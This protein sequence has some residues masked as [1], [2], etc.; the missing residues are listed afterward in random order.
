M[1]VLSLRPVG[2]AVGEYLNAGGV[3]S[4][5]PVHYTASVLVGGTSALTDDDDASYVY[6]GTGN[7]TEAGT[8]GAPYYGM[9]QDWAG[10]TLPAVTVDPST[11]TDLTIRARFKHPPVADESKLSG[12]GY[13]M[14][15]WLYDATTD[16]TL[17]LAGW[18][19]TTTPAVTPGTIH[20]FSLSLFDA[21]T[22][23]GLSP[24]AAIA[25][26]QSSYTNRL[27]TDSCEILTF[28]YAAVPNSADYATD[29][30]NF[31]QIYEVELFVTYT[32]PAGSISG[33]QHG[34]RRIMP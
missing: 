3:A 31:V 13:S 11:I 15:V 10:G 9:H 4:F 29:Y 14:G 24:A 32:P 8:S 25:A 16:E 21:A 30:P 2:V 7:A 18:D 27:T 34:G 5:D 33:T 12:N 20:D 26:I 28:G 22:A 1:A 19:A 6:L 23:G 17:S